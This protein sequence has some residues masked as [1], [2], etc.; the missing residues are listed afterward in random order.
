MQPWVCRSSASLMRGPAPRLS[1]RALRNALAALFLAISTAA[2]AESVEEKAVICGACHGLNGAPVD[3]SIPII[4]GQNSPYLYVQFHD[5]QKGLRSDERMSAVA[6]NVVKQDAVA[7][8]EFFAAR[9]WPSLDAPKATAAETE[10]AKAA[11]DSAGC[12]TC[13]TDEYR[14]SFVAPRL[15][16]QHREYLLKT[17]MEFHD[18]TRSNSPTMMDVT[19]LLTPEQLAAI[20]AYLAG[21]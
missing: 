12:V 5:F 15:A 9:P 18:Q 10:T 16:G 17:L 11:M 7:L 1:T 21:L 19:A 2:I 13:H 4:W 3:P 20:A 14:G 6:K 8:A